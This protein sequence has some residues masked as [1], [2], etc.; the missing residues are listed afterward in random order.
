MLWK[1]KGLIHKPLVKIREGI[2][3]KAVSTKSLYKSEAKKAKD[4]NHLKKKHTPRNKRKITQ[5]I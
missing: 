5:A 4:T 3:E 1:E 2:L